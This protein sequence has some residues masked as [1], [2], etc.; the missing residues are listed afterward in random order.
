MTDETRIGDS[1]REAAL[2]AL[3]QHLTAGR[4]ELAEFDERARLVTSARTRGELAPVF[5]DLP[6]PHA[7][8]APPVQLS[9]QPPEAAARQHASGRTGRPLF[10]RLGETAVALSPFI[11]LGL[12]LIFG[13]WWVWLLIPVAGIVVYGNRKDR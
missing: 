8:A 2:A 6:A 5:A 1:D 7:I 13:V 10:G 11:A 3:Q 4:I 12:F 9:K